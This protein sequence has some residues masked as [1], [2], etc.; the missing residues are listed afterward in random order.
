MQVLRQGCWRPP[1]VASATGQQR[2]NRYTVV[3]KASLMNVYTLGQYFLEG[4][5]VHHGRTPSKQQDQ[6]FWIP[7]CLR[8]TELALKVLTLCPLPQFTVKIHS[9][10]TK[11]LIS[12]NKKTN[13]ICILVACSIYSAAKQGDIH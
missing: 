4:D 3:D 8:T 1:E 13:E 2:G 12:C 6:T 7:L 5:P 10:F 11:I 9:S